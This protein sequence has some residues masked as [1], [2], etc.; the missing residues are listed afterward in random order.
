MQ[1]VKNKK[2]SKFNRLGKME[3]KSLYRHLYRHCEDLGIKK[4]SPDLGVVK[5]GTR[6]ELWNMS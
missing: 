4:K 3:L 6:K 2:C 5:I 1:W